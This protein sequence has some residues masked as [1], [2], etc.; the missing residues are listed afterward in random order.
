MTYFC[1]ALRAQLP[2]AAMVG[3]PLQ[4]AAAAD[5]IPW[6]P[7]HLVRVPFHLGPRRAQPLH[8]IAGDAALG[9]LRVD[10][11][12]ARGVETEDL[13][14]HVVGERRVAV[15]VRERRI[16]LERAEGHN[17]RLRRSA[18]DAV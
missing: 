11:I 13:A 1:C 8:F 9:D 14:L 10:A 4:N 2:A 16:D 17:L 7:A 12:E 3:E 6:Q 5:R 15:L 18:P